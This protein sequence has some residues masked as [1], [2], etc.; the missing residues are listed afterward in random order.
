MRTPAVIGA[1]VLAASSGAG[2]V[3]LS[4]RVDRPSYRSDEHSYAELRNDGWRVAYG[5]FCTTYSLERRCG[6][7]WIPIERPD[8]TCT[9]ELDG[10]APGSSRAETFHVPRETSKGTYRLVTHVEAGGSDYKVT[11]NEFL[12]VGSAITSACAEQTAAPRPVAYPGSFSREMYKGHTIVADER[13]DPPR[14]E[15][16]G[17]DIRVSRQQSFAAGGPMFLTPVLS[18]SMSPTLVDLASTVI[19]TGVLAFEG[20]GP[21]A[22]RRRPNCLVRSTE[23]CIPPEHEN[24]R[25]GHH[26]LSTLARFGAGT[27]DKPVRCHVWV[28]FK[29]RGCW[30]QTRARLEG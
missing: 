8:R 13:S 27:C 2:C 23:S 24:C 4:L 1:I 6:T 26:D 18:Y 12:I 7:A 21:D 29:Q 14:L 25:K 3:S 5:N 15:I 10:Y 11:S 28:E 22:I 16:D 17:R 20:V 9:K 19:D 30:W